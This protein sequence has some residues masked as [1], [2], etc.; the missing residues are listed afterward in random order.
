LDLGTY[1][2]LL[3]LKAIKHLGD[4]FLNINKSFDTHCSQPMNSSQEA[5]LMFD[6]LP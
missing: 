1:D 2:A 5:R 6:S 4:V 3:Y